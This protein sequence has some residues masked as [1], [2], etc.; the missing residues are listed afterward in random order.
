MHR[1]LVIALVAV[2]SCLGLTGVAQAGDP[3]PVVPPASVPPTPG[4]VTDDASAETFAK[5]YAARNAGRFLRSDR[6]R[7]R[8]LD[9]NAACLQSPVVATRFGCVFTLRALVILRR[10]RGWDGR[11]KHPVAAPASRRG[12]DHG[13]R[14]FRI[15]NYGCLGFLRINGGPA[16][17]PTAQV[18]N[19]EC[20]RVPRDDI[21]APE[22]V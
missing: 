22:P 8:V 9:V 11:D 17:T 21:V 20:G 4:P 5:A 12:G 19:V 2:A 6:R 10:S 7:V 18:I 16:V 13:H 3:E 15:R 14:R 1:I